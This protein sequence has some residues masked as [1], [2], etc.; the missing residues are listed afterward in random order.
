MFSGLVNVPTTI[1]TASTNVLLVYSIRITNRTANTIRINVQKVRTQNIPVSIFY[2]NEFE[3]EAYATTEIVSP[4]TKSEGKELPILLEYSRT[5]SISDSLK[6]FS[7]GYTQEF[8]CEIT[9][10]QLNELPFN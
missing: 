3:I 1:L 6:C 10:M 7:N 5:P 4:P 2:I 9:Y 8:D